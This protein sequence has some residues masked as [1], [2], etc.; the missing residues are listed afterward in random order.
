MCLSDPQ[1]P[2]CKLCGELTDEIERLQARVA[3][4]EGA[5]RYID[6]EAHDLNAAEECARAALAATEQGERSGASDGK[7]SWDTEQEGECNECKGTGL[8]RSTLD[9]PMCDGTGRAATEQEGE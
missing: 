7:T 2:S 5:L 9:C 3:A 8:G 4:L 1:I 6:D